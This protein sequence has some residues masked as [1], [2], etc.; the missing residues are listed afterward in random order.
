V[1][2]FGLY[3]AVCGVAESSAAGADVKAESPKFAIKNVVAEVDMT[4][5][6]FVMAAY[7]VAFVS[8]IGMIARTSYLYYRQSQQLKMLL[9]SG[10]E[11]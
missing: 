10:Y 1:D 8:L 6:N 3:G 7:G 9:K 2:G 4:H 11:G 5:I